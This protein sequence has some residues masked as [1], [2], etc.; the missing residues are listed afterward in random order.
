VRE[1]PRWAL[2]DL[3]GDGKIEDSSPLYGGDGI[4]T[5]N[6][7]GAKPRH[8]SRSSDQQETTTPRREENVSSTPVAVEHAKASYTHYGQASAPTVEHAPHA[9]VA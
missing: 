9:A 4:L 2:F 3:N 7:S 1:I 8:P 6:V 5:W